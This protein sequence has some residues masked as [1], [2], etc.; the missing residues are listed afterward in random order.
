MK[1]VTV[2]MKI[3]QLYRLEYNPTYG[4]FGVLL[5]DGSVFCVTLELPWNNNQTDISCIPTGQYTCNKITSP[6]FGVVFE[7][8]G[9]PNRVDVLLHI[10]N[11][12]KDTH[13][14]ILLGSSFIEDGNRG[15]AQ[16]TVMFNHFM[17]VL[18]NDDS[19]TLTIA[20]ADGT[21]TV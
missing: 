4:T 20:N 9:V 12:T 17:T 14:C 6:K 8:Q 10:G 1:E 5:M 13:G 15:I 18:N 16:S 21:T 19:F 7:V 11:Y 2:N 3:F